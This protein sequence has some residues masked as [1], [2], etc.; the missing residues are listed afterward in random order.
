MQRNP[1]V[2]VPIRMHR[3]LMQTQQATPLSQALSCTKAAERPVNKARIQV[4]GVQMQYNAPYSRVLS[5]ITGMQN[6][7]KAVSKHEST[8]RASHADKFKNS[9]HLRAS[10]GDPSSP[11]GV[12][13][14]QY[15]KSFR[16]RR[17]HI[18]EEPQKGQETDMLSFQH[19]D[20]T[21]WSSWH[22]QT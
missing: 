14:C 3:I 12:L 15:Q 9:K 21:R 19:A 20:T 22:I 17:H 6:T 13:A 18:K 16:L 7:L 4:R 11:P 5:K 2:C 10:W 8:Q 1:E